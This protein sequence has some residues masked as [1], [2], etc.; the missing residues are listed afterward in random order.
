VDL[1]DQV[2]TTAA[3]KV[4]RMDLIHRLRLEEQHIP[5]LVVVEAVGIML[6]TYWHMVAQEGVEVVAEDKLDKQPLGAVRHSRI[7]PHFL[8]LEMLVEIQMVAP[9]EEVAVVWVQQA[10]L[11]LA[12]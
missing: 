4:V 6:Q 3:I 12:V 11:L 1:G 10:Q 7:C 5:V 8:L 2:E 9:A